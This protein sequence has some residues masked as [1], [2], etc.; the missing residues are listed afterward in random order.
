MVA[1]ATPPRIWPTDPYAD[2]VREARALRAC[3]L[4]AVAGGVT[5]LGFGLA[6]LLWPE[7][8]PSSVA[9]TLGGWLLAAGA[10]RLMDAAPPGEAGSV[11]R[12]LSAVA[13]L[14]YL[15]VGIVC[16]RHLLTSVELM[17]IVVGIAWFAGGVTEIMS[18]VTGG[19]GGWVRLGPV[20]AGAIAVLGGLVLAFWP[21]ISLSTL[22]LVCGAWLLANG[23]LHV[24][25]AFRAGRPAIA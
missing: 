9:T 6:L 17:A 12:A 3:R 11:S 20:A 1:A 15:I 23:A 19:R 8:S 24:A 7:R 25:L 4:L 10:L 18:A 2:N 5:S 22:V 21:G 13:G 16:V 14:H